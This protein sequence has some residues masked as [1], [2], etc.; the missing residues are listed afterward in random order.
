MQYRRVGRSGLKVSTLSLSGR[1]ALEENV[2]EVHQLKR[3]L[4]VALERGVNRLDLADIDGAGEGERLFGGLLADYPRHQLVLS[5]KCYWPMSQGINDRGLSRKH[6]M[7][8][9]ESSLKRLGTDYLDLFVCQAFDEETPLEETARAIEDLISQGKVLYWG[10][11]GWSAES[12]Y[13]ACNLADRFKGYAPIAALPLYNLHERGVEQTLTP[14]A[15]A[16]SVGL[17]PW[18]P[19]AGGSLVGVE[20]RAKDAAWLAPWQTPEAQERSAALA[21]LASEL[22]HTPAQLA[23]AWLL[24]RPLVSSVTLHTTQE[25]HLRDAL[26]AADL[27]LTPDTLSALNALTP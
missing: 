26:E 14:A 3:L 21:T 5:T 25:P 11:S 6:I 17:L 12:L 4:S 19:L 23:I 16:L 2:R 27:I 13:Q 8:S 22:G 1:V 20:P 7:E 9:V 15:Q 18:S 10:V 24:S